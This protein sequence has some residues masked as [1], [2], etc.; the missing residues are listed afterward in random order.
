MSNEKPW[1]TPKEAGVLLNMTGRN[2]TNLIHKGKISASKDEDGRY[3]ID[4]TEIYRVYPHVFKAERE[5]NEKKPA[6]NVSLKLL[7]EKVNL[8]Q[9]LISEK[10]K[11]N[12]FL[13]EQLQNATTEKS[14]MLDSI[15]SQARLLEYK[16][17]RPTSKQQKKT[18]FR[19]PFKR[20]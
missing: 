17:T 11:Q 3:Y 10:K 2:V 1:L 9:E 18:A 12:E 5:R 7:E 20:K 16:E 13:I 14:K 15:N 6:E 4:R 19:W 8:L